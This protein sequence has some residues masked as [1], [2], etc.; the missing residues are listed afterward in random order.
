M[1]VDGW[2]KERGQLIISKIWEKKVE[3]D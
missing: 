1:G 2:I 3:D